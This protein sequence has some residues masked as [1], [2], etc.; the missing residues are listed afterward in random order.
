MRE[1]VNMKAKHDSPFQP[2][3]TEKKDHKDDADSSFV[4]LNWWSHKLA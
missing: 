2:V 4:L 3:Q 1:T